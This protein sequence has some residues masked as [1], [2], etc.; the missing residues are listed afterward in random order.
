MQL[1]RILASLLVALCLM[2]V[3]IGGNQPSGL[4]SPVSRPATDPLVAGVGRERIAVV[5]LQGAIDSSGGG[6]APTGALAIRNQLRRLAEDANVKGV[7]LQI[8]SGG[9]T[10]GASQELYRAV[11]AVR[12]EKPIV[13]TVQDVAASGAYYAASATNAILANPGSLVG[14]IGVIIQGIT[15]T[16]LLDEIGVEAATIK[17]GQYKDIL[18]PFRPLS[19]ADRD[20]LQA[21]VQDTYEQF[22][23]DVADGR[24]VVSEEAMDILGEAAVTR[25]KAMTVDAVRA[26]ADGRIL[27]GR[28]AFEAGLVD[29][30]GGQEEAIATLKQ[31]IGDEDIAVEGDRLNFDTFWRI[32][33]SGAPSLAGWQESSVFQLALDRLTHA[34]GNPALSLRAEA[35]V[36]L[37][38]ESLGGRAIAGQ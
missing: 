20:L 5:S 7:L 22:V 15:A 2:A 6:L 16:E 11:E 1:N 17:T 32:L 24:Q 27:S 38:W 9:G 3:V 25:R 8:N 14:S 12:N 31:W 10:V 13:A 30:L 35:D 21:L 4:E 29:E 34:V 18:S 26:L 37:R 36:P 28:Q 19:E 33:Q 23:S